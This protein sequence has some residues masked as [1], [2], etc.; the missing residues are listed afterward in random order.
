MQ[1]CLNPAGSPTSDWVLVEKLTVKG[2]RQYTRGDV[3]VLWAPDN[4][5]QQIIKRLLAVEG[6][7]ILEDPSTGTTVDITQGHCWVEGDNTEHSG[8]SKTAYGP[9][10]VGLLEGH[11]SHIVWPPSRMGR[12]AVLPQPERILETERAAWA[13]SP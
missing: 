3:V 2:F 13:P 4:P 7:T 11:V 6:D 8:D 12:V 10:H 9:V 1:P 5:H